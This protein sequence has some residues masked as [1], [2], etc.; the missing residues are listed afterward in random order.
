MEFE[1]KVLSSE[2]QRI[3]YEAG[4]TLST[5]ESCTGGHI[6][7]SIIAV[8]GSSEY[9]KGGI[10]SYTNDSRNASSNNRL[11][12]ITPIDKIEETGIDQL[13]DRAPLE[14]ALAYDPYGQRLHFGCDDLQALQFMVSV[15]DQSGHRVLRFPAFEGCSVDRLPK[16]IYIVTCHDRGHHSTKFLK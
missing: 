2:I 4:L 10:I 1:N 16:G 11:W 14:Y 9:F 6:A 3:M 12:A 5:A 15:Y 13:H 7:E 8:P